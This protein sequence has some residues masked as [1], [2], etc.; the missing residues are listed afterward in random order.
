VLKKN[1]ISEV[2][3][4]RPFFVTNVMVIILIQIV[5]L[6]KSQIN[7]FGAWPGSSSSLS[8]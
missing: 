4:K 5:F 1:L 6:T 8:S 3:F 2:L 7:I